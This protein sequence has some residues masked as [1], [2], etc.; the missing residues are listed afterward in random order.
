M[1]PATGGSGS[2]ESLLGAAYTRLSRFAEA[3]PYLLR[4]Y[5]LLPVAPGSEGPKAR[6]ARANLARLVAL[7]EAWGRPEKAAPY[8]LRDLRGNDPRWIG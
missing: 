1:P 6:E 5:E 2:R 7:Y 8:R 4:A 3:E